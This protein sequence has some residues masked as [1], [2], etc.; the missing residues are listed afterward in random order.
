MVFLLPGT[1]PLVPKSLAYGRRSL[2]RPEDLHIAFDV[3][4][5]VD[6][7][8]FNSCLMGMIEVFHR[9]SGKVDYGISSEGYTPATSWPYDKILSFL[10]NS[11]A[12]VP[13]EKLAKRIVDEYWLLYDGSEVSKEEGIDL[14]AC[15]I[16]KSEG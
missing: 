14:S 2:L 11:N 7:V 6:I 4:Q 3:D 13:P 5:K 10:Q 9:L 12:E 1:P 15:D 16:Q 8:G